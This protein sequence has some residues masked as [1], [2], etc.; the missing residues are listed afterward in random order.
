MK[1]IIFAIVSIFI[2]TNGYTQT[3]GFRKI[4]GNDLY[5]QTDYFQMN[6]SNQLPLDMSLYY[7][8]VDNIEEYALIIRFI[9]NDERLNVPDGA[10]LKMKTAKGT[11]IDAVQRMGESMTVFFSESGTRTSISHHCY[12]Y[13]KGYVVTSKYVLSRQDLQTLAEEGLVKVRIQTNAENIDCDYPETEFIKV[14]RNRQE[15]NRGKINFYEWFTLL[16]NNIDP[17]TTF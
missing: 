14:S 9:V 7:Q 16:N 15:I 1:K 13:R 11:V 17:Y 5:M 8:C 12:E 10:R 2:L 6:A 3:I 4:L